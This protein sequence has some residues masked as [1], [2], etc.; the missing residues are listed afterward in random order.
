MLLWPLRLMSVMFELGQQC[1]CASHAH[2]CTGAPHTRALLDA[3][4]GP[5]VLRRALHR[6]CVACT[7]WS[8]LSRSTRRPKASIFLKALS[9]TCSTVGRP[10]CSSW[11]RMTGAISGFARTLI[12]SSRLS[13]LLWKCF[14][15]NPS[16][17]RRFST[18]YRICCTSVLREIW[19]AGTMP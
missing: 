11:L 19:W 5:A 3:G 9:M 10:H 1:T 13:K 15:G 14:S 18:I 4:D 16:I 6:T 7:S 12:E 17:L 2:A 8:F